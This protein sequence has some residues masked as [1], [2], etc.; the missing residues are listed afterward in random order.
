[1]RM[2]HNLKVVTV[3]SLFDSFQFLVFI[4][5]PDM[6]CLLLG[7]DPIWIGHFQ[8]LCCAIVLC[9]KHFTWITAA[10][11]KLSFPSKLYHETVFL[12]AACSWEL[13]DLKSLTFELR[14][15]KAFV[16]KTHESSICLE[17]LFFFPHSLTK[18]RLRTLPVCPKIHSHL[19]NTSIRCFLNLCT[20]QHFAIHSAK[21]QFQILLCKHIRYGKLGGGNAK[22]TP[23]LSWISL[24]SNRISGFV[25]MS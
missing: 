15:L 19:C 8:S 21:V 9:P 7:K 24:E 3:A 23:S 20:F 4:S 11:L 13:K 10:E 16:E 25:M 2:K 14:I 6:F 5:L 18:R 1:M 22:R 17:E 12:L